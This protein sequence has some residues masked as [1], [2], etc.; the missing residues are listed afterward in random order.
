[1]VSH[2]FH[3]A[4]VP[5]TF[6]VTLKVS[7]DSIPPL[8][9]TFVMDIRITDPPHPPVSRSKA[10]YWV[11]ECDGDTLTLDGSDSFDPDQGLH[12]AGCAACPIDTITAWDWDFD[13]ALF[14]Y[15]SAHGKI[16]NLGAGF[17]GT[18]PEAK[19]YDIGLRVTDNTALAYPASG[20][21]NL[22]D[23]GFSKVF[24]FEAA[25]CDLGAT[26]RCDSVHLA[27]TSTG[28]SSYHVYRSFAGPNADFVKVLNAGAASSA[29][30]PATLG[31]GQWFRVMGVKGDD[32]SLSKTVFVNP[33]GTDCVCIIDLKAA[34]KNRRVQLSWA[35]SP[36][37]TC[38]N[39]YRSTTAN[40]PVDAG[41]RIA[42]CVV[43]GVAVYNDT[44]VVNGTKHYYKVTKVVDG[45]ETCVSTEAS[46]TPALPRR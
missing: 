28:A 41:H 32:Q 33:T 21:P 43:T 1:M 26:P 44:A 29:D 30:I 27:W 31:Q 20:S 13:G 35:P 2:P 19:A 36:G 46:A 34:A 6:P 17:G 38:Y 42:S 3:C 39:V 15:P 11:S 23:E 37:A 25:A 16:V 8:S 45:V 9:A 18:F 5:C 12:Q 14:D 10:I 22:T 24:V 4:A 40:V 7:D